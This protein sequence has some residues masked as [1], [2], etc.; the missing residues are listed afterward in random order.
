MAAVAARERRDVA[1]ALEE[2]ARIMAHENPGVAREIGWFVEALKLRTGG[3]DGGRGGRGEPGSIAVEGDSVRDDL[4]AGGWRDRIGAE[5]DE[6]DRSWA[7]AYGGESPAGKSA[8]NLNESRSR[9]G[10][11]SWAA[12]PA[13]DG[14]I[15]DS[16]SQRP[17]RTGNMPVHSR[18]PRPRMAR[19]TKGAVAVLSA[20]RSFAE[21]GET[22]RLSDLSMNLQ[23]QRR[24]MLHHG[25]DVAEEEV[26]ES[27]DVVQRLQKQVTALVDRVRKLEGRADKAEAA[28]AAAAAAPAVGLDVSWRVETEAALAELR[29]AHFALT[30]KHEDAGATHS[31]ELVAVQERLAATSTASNVS[32]W[33]LTRRAAQ[34]A[35]EIADALRARVTELEGQTKAGKEVYHTLQGQLAAVNHRVLKLASRAEAGH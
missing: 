6:W 23:A 16:R 3:E 1:D 29:A 20:V 22:R 35:R 13:E 9:R 19:N 15:L 4:Q 30:Q 10:D 21:A 12:T 17:R 32:E 2:F 8:A 25:D 14:K 27:S 5:A 31:S 24:E 28:G 34:E 18:A 26:A 33:E 11:Q 7:Q